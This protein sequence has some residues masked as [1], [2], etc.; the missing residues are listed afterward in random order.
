MAIYVKIVKSIK[1]DFLIDNAYILPCSGLIS[2]ANLNGISRKP[3]EKS[4]YCCKTIRLWR[5]YREDV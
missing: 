2:R 1:C 4:C 3:S 5:A